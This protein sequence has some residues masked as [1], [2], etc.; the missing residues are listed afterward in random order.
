M[1]EFPFHS[2]ETV[3][4]EAKPV[5][6]A[7]QQVTGSSTRYSRKFAGLHGTVEG[8]DFGERG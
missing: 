5:L 2:A 3:P 8:A 7:T 4:E 1:I 6:D